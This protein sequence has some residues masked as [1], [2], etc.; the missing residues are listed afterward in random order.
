MDYV[1]VHESGRD[2][3]SVEEKMVEKIKELSYDG[4]KLQGG[5]SIA[6]NSDPRCYLIEMAQAMIKE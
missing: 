5:I 3:D 4:W 2:Y 6:F 1:V